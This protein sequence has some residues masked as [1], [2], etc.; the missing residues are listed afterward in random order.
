MALKINHSSNV[1]AGDILAGELP[2]RGKFCNTI[3]SVALVHTSIRSDS[4]CRQK[5]FSQPV[6]Q[7][8]RSRTQSCPETSTANSHLVRAK[9]GSTEKLGVI[10]KEEG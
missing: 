9:G 8:K 7:N 3:A 2:N 5:K 4:E 1:R 10:T 6:I